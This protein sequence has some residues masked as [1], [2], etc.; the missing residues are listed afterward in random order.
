MTITT[1]THKIGKIK[2]LIDLNGNMTNFE[3][4]F[5]VSNKDNK[6]FN[7]IVVDQTSLDSGLELEYKKVKGSIN[8]NLVA[9]KNIYQNYF[10]ILKA[11]EECDCE[12]TLDINELP[13]QITKEQEEIEEINE[14]QHKPSLR[15]SSNNKKFNWLSIKRILLIICLLFSIYCVYH[16][17]FRKNET[18]IINN[19]EY[20][21]AGVS[22]KFNEKDIFSFGNVDTQNNNTEQNF[23]VIS[24]NSGN[25][26]S[27]NSENLEIFNNIRRKMMKRPS[28][29]T[30]LN[31]IDL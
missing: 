21:D 12:V 29:S 25:S 18:V 28:I 13:E 7:I 17:Y 5:T 6:E 16:F 1:S 23:E 26:D 22:S 8:G 14:T 20:I 19:E 10:L 31:K 15:S 2:K 24:V 11:D 9:D 27:S 4:N 30:R 3:L